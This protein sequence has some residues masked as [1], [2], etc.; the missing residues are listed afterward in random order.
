LVESTI[1][2]QEP[3]PKQLNDRKYIIRIKIN[4]KDNSDTFKIKNL[5]FINNNLVE[6]LNNL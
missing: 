4:F 2:A 3:T 5:A 1:L 6:F